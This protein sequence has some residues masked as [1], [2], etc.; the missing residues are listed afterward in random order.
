MNLGLWPF[1]VFGMS[2]MEV[3]NFNSLDELRNLDKGKPYQ[4]RI[5]GAVVGNEPVIVVDFQG[6]IDYGKQ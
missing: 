3:K 5:G 2:K 1:T 6:M 4:V